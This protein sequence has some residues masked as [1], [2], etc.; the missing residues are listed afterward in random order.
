MKFREMRV[1]KLKRNLKFKMAKYRIINRIMINWEIWS[2][3]RDKNAKLSINYKK[4]WILIG[5]VYYYKEI[6]RIYRVNNNKNWMA[7]IISYLLSQIVFNLKIYH[8]AREWI[9]F[10]NIPE[11]DSPNSS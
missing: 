7:P 3:S 6:N 9:I 5:M 1:K 10:S 4:R 2:N 8:P 11:K